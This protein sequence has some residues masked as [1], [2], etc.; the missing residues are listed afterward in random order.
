[1]SDINSLVAEIKQ[2]TKFQINKKI[3]KEKIQTDLHMPY[4]NGLFKIT[5]EILA[6]VR[7]WPNEILYIEDV[8]ENPVLIQQQEFV[9]LAQQHYQK[10]M[11]TWHQQYEEL[12]Q[13]R[14]V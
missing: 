6:F 10:V 9:E 8:Y 14:K 3:L 1:M 2:A 11:N 12:K 7:T 4:N 5:P 13:I